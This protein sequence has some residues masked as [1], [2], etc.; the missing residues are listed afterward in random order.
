M[1]CSSKVKKDTYNPGNTNIQNK[2]SVGGLRKEQRRGFRG[3]ETPNKINLRD[4][5]ATGLDVHMY[6]PHP[7]YSVK[8]KLISNSID[9][10]SKHYW[11]PTVWVPATHCM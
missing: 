2:L 11:A 8:M 3:R 7:K 4:R 6:I 5:Q 1:E 10:H 9:K